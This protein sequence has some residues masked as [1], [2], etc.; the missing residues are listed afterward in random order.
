M[1]F[2]IKKRRENENKS[3]VEKV[4]LFQELLL[5]ILQLSDHERFKLADHVPLDGKQILI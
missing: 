1:R 2:Y 5:M 3:Y 4:N